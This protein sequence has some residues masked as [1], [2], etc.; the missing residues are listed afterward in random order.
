MKRIS[1]NFEIPFIA[2]GVPT[3]ILRL[4]Q[5]AIQTFIKRKTKIVSRSGEIGSKNPIFF[6]RF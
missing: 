5:N 4:I 2:R 1:V 3:A 6:W